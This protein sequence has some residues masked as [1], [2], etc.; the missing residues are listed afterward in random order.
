LDLIKDNQKNYDA[1]IIGY[2]KAGKTL[3]KEYLKRGMKVALIE[4]S[5]QLYGGTCINVACIPSKVLVTFAKNA[6]VVNA[7]TYLDKAFFYQKAMSEKKNVVTLLRDKSYH[8][9]ADQNN[10]DIYIGQASF[11]SDH[12]VNITSDIASI[13]TIYGDKI[14][15]NTGSMPIIPEIEGLK[16]G[17]HIYTSEE[18][19]A[20][21][22]LPKSLIILGGGYIAT[23]FASIYASFGSKVTI[24]QDGPTFLPKEDEDTRLAVM[25]IFKKKGIDF[26]LDFKTQKIEIYGDEITVKGS[27][28]QDTFNVRGNNLLIATGRRPNIAL[29]NLEA[30]G[31]LVNDKGIEVNEFNQTSKPHIYAM[32]D[33]NGGPQYTYISLD[34]YRIVRNHVFNTDKYNK[35]DR[36]NI[37]YNIFI[38]PPLARVGL[39]ETEAKGL[40]IKVVKLPTASIPKAQVLGDTAGF[41][42]VIIEAKTSL[43]LGATFICPEAH[44]LINIIKLVMDQKLPYTVLKD[45]IFTHPTM[46]EAFNDLFALV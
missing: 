15:I 46:A 40:D 43:I 3:A 31:V 27:K 5:Q 25:E 10:I 18:L 9:L 35:L 26:F 2:G 12:E 6:H 38:D 7:K 39:S 16:L 36:I 42:K 24:V 45:Q 8:D 44:E 32:G 30:A 1:I 41:L 33:C 29:L 20:E 19:L 21:E 11:K 28:G 14:F 37:P 13:E 23:E 34:D 4:K 22:S 17:K